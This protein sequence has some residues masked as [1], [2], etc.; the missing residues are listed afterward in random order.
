M[1]ILC[2]L[3]SNLFFFSGQRDLC[4][5]RASVCRRDIPG[6][7]ELPSVAGIDGIHSGG[8]VHCF[9]VQ[10]VEQGGAS[11]HLWRPPAGWYGLAVPERGQTSITDS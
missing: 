10:D 7:P 8:I 9:S 1:F 6:P 2:A 5:C 11:A 4:L 3:S